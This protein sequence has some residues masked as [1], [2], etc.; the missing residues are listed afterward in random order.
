[1]TITARR[2]IAIVGTF[3]LMMSFVGCNKTSYDQNENIIEAN[4]LKERLSDVETIVID[5]RSQED[6]EKGH[7]VGAIHLAPEALTVSEPVPGLIAP[8]E[9]VEA[10]LSSKGIKNDSKIYIYDNK[11]GIY[12]AR[13][14]WVL[15][16][17]GH[18][19]VKVINN[20]EKAIVQNGFELTLDVPEITPSTYQAAPMDESMI[21]TMEDVLRVVEGES[22]GVI[23]DTRSM[24]EYDEGA[25]PGAILFP[26]TKNL[27]T[28]GSFKSPRDV[29]LDYNDLGIK[30]E[31][32]VIVYC[33][34]SVRATQTAL[35]LKEAGFTDVKVYDGAWLEW[36]TKDTPKTEK[37]EEVVP[38][39]QDAS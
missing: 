5:A 12:A 19:D 33:K 3:I 6:Y 34:S 22:E 20:G 25:V 4:L 37:S 35:L 8:L 28:D 31:D 29:Y 7:M 10:V 16:I 36:S 9:T 2:L 38:S 24:A 18:Q 26:H 30:R 32:A 14:W 15:K 13:L 11:E 1:M 39:T 17:H 27:Y 23:I 21:A